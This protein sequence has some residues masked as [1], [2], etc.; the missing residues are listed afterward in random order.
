MKNYLKAYN[1]FLAL[2]WAALLLHFM[3]YDFQLDNIGLLLLNICQG[4]AILEVVHAILKWV[5]SPIVTTAIQVASRVFILVLI[6]L[7]GF[8][9][10]FTIWGIN[11]LH[12]IMVAW[13]ITEIVRYSLYLLNLLEKESK[14]LLFCRYTFFIVLYP[15][16]VAGELL[17]IYSYLMPFEFSL[18]I[19]TASF[20]TLVLIYLIFFPKLYLHM[21]A[22]RK[23]KLA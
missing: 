6:N 5:S 16:G 1:L 13:S 2:G 22:Q 20:A 7:I 12:L 4:A 3:Y 21:W 10:Y 23:K 8:E 17:I 15:A 18:N 19:P 11:G 14:V 9:G